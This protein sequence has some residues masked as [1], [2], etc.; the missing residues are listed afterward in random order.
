M[1][2]HSAMSPQAIR[3]HC[4]CLKTARHVA[5]RLGLSDDA[6]TVSFQSQVGRE[7]WLRPYT[8]EQLMQ[9]ARQGRKRVLVVCPGFATD[10][11]ETLE[12]IGLRNRATFLANGGEHYDYVP[13][14]NASGAH[15][16]LLAGLID[17][18]ASGWSDAGPRPERGRHHS[19]ARAATRSCALMLG[20]FLEI[21]LHTPD[22][23]ESLEF[24]ESLGFA[25]AS[26]G[27]IWPH[28]YAV[29]TDGR[30]FLGLHGLDIVRSRR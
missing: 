5:E 11:L 22:I 21:S 15:A 28:P 25:Q 1:A 23:Q 13:A 29:V 10:C 20:R 2:F 6:W 17:R 24:Y 12:E 19:G 30:L 8:D 16:T 18:H 7:E 3:T 27:E 4:H 26:V 9:F 14:L